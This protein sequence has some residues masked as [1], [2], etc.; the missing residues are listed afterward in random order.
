MAG[1]AIQNVQTV[2]MIL[3]RHALRK[4]ETSKMPS[5]VVEDRLGLWEQY[6]CTGPKLPCRSSKTVLKVSTTTSAS[7]ADTFNITVLIWNSKPWRGSPACIFGRVGVSCTAQSSRRAL[8]TFQF[9]VL[10]L[11]RQQTNTTCTH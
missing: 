11:T 4:L 3:H 6:H 1:S 5:A 10:H 9:L 8:P 7:L 2:S